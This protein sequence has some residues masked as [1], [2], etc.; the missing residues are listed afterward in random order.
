VNLS[1]NGLTQFEIQEH[2][3]EFED[4]LTGLKKGI[5]AIANLL[6]AVSLNCGCILGQAIVSILVK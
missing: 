2:K 5:L 1:R 6:V 3:P 4:D